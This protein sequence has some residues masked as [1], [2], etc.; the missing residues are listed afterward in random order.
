[1]LG[2]NITSPGRGVFRL[3]RNDAIES[4]EYIYDMVPF[5]KEALAQVDDADFGRLAGLWRC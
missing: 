1:V 3:C 5:A 2:A 4:R